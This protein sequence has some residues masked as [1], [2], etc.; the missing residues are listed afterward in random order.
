MLLFLSLL[1]YYNY[2]CMILKRVLYCVYFPY[3]TIFFTDGV[4]SLFSLNALRFSE[5]FSLY[6]CTMN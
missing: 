4:I 5:I 2:F 6:F 1:N 3:F